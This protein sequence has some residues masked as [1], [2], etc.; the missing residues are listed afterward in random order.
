MTSSGTLFLA[1]WMFSLMVV[2]VALTPDRAS[3]RERGR[4]NLGVLNSTGER[5]GGRS[6]LEGSEVP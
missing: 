2:T 4:A 6:T 1:S 3:S 5:A